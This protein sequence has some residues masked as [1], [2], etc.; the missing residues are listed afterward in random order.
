MAISVSPTRYSNQL[1]TPQATSGAVG[2]YNIVITPQ[3]TYAE[4]ESVS[5]RN[6]D[7]RQPQLPAFVLAAHYTAF[8]HK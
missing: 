7:Q 5:W 3:P 1:W 2:P 6:M 4:V 8:I